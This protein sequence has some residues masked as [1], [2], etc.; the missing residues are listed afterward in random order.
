MHSSRMR[1]ACF[2]AVRMMNSDVQ[3]EQVPTCAGAGWRIPV[4]GS[5]GSPFVMRSNTSWIIVKWTRLP[6][7]NRMTQH[8]WKHYLA[9]TLLAGG[10]MIKGCNGCL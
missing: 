2:P 1:A 4:Q 5:G 3:V 6:L 10:K 7:L 9:T 8:N